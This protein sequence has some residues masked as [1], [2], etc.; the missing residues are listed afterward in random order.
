M[1]HDLRSLEHRKQ[2][3]IEQRSSNM[4]FIKL[5]HIASVNNRRALQFAPY[6]SCECQ[7]SYLEM[8]L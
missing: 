2:L 3:K 7:T 8:M 4:Y 5:I 1:L 6:G